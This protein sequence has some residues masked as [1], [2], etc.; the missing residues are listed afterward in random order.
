M[1]TFTRPVTGFSHS[2]QKTRPPTLYKMTLL[3]I[4]GLCSAAAALTVSTPIS[5]DRLSVQLTAQ[6]QQSGVWSAA[7]CSLAAS[8]LEE[9]GVVLVK[10]AVP[11]ELIARCSE[12]VESRF[13]AC[14]TALAGKGVRL[15]DPFAFKEIAHRSKLRYDMQL[16][17]DCPQE[18]IDSPPWQPML[19]KV[20]GQPMALFQGAVIANPGAAPQQPHMDGSH[21]FQAT[22]GYEQVQAPMHCLN[23]FLPLVDVTAENGPTEFWPGSHVLANARKAYAG[24]M[25]SVA[26]A[27][28][29]TDAIVFDY[30]VVHR[31]MANAGEAA[32]PVLYLTFCR[33]WFRDQQNF[34][35]ERLF[36][37]AAG[38]GAG[39]GGGGGGGGGFGARTVPGKKG[40][41]TK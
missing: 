33:S 24:Q 36:P 4:I 35:D 15:Q 32:R 14:Q 38:G 7:T 13:A 40:K 39:G 8:L 20:F 1:L 2:R 37:L 28:A 9:H 6:E 10:R 22:H 25:P 3:P 41:G 21:L 17:G 12:A 11:V 29:R 34:P 30:R 27:G 23:V 19:K 16:A 26:L 5:A 18:L 31:G